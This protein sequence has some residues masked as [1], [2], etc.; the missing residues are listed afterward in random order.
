RICLATD[1]R[2]TGS[3][4]LLEELRFARSAAPVGDRELLDMVT[5]APARVLRLAGGTLAA[6]GVADLIV[7]PPASDTPAG[8]LLA[9]RRSDLE[10]VSVGGR[11][12]IGAARFSQA[13]AARQV[14]TVGIGVDGVERVADVRLAARIRGCAIQEPGIACV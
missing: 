7:V 8:A 12:I 6:G 14:R 9:M 4:D 11:P 13:F 10:L 2:V 5:R 3:R 1:S